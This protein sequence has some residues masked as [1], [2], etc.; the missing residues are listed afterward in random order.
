MYSKSLKCNL[1]LLGDTFILKLCSF[2]LF[3]RLHL[4]RLQQQK[5][6]HIWF[7]GMSVA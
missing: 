2:L 5:G 7:P 6:I 1:S 4:S 3:I